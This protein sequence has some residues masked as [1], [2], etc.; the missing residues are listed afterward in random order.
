[1]GGAMVLKVGGQI[2][3]SEVS[4]KIFVFPPVFGNVG[5]KQFF[6]FYGKYSNIIFSFNAGIV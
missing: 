4:R 3:T 1:M 5:E 2:L 6:R